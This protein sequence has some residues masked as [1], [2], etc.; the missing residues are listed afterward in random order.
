MPEWFADTSGWGNLFDTSQPYHHQTANLYRIA[1][2]QGQPIVTT[3]YVLT[4]LVAL[5]TSPLKMSRPQI[6]QIVNSIKSSPNIEIVHIDAAL[7][8]KAW[9]LL[10][11]R[12]DKTWSLVDCASFVLMQER[13]ISDAL[14]ADHHFEQAGFT[15]LLK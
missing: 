6:I 2:Q 1:H 9:Q 5:L 10:V 15:R 14:T 8:Q 7:D 12:Q 4:E 13:G 11:S 3:N